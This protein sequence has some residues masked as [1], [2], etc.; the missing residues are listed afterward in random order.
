VPALDTFGITDDRD[1][2]MAVA[3]LAVEQLFDY[4]L[5][6]LQLELLLAALADARALDEP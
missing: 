5:D 4:G 1:I 3:V 2:L 6:A